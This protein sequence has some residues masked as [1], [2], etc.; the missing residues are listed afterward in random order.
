MMKSELLA[1]LQA[2]AAQL[3]EQ[4]WRAR[5]EEHQYR[6]NRQP[7]WAT[8]DNDNQD[9]GDVGEVLPSQQQKSH[10]RHSTIR[11]SG[12]TEGGAPPPHPAYRQADDEG[13]SAEQEA[14]Q[15]MLRN[16][17]QEQAPQAPHCPVWDSSNDPHGST[18]MQV[19]TAASLALSECLPPIA[20]MR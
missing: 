4:Q 20:R 3:S 19:M 12:R 18:P 5:Q 14:F 9:G 8:H 15:R 13:I 17:P 11:G 7:P 10:D 2:E 1:Q 16:D 6:Y